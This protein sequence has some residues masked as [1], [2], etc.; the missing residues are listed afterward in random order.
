MKP[1]QP[2]GYPK[3]AIEF[4]QRNGP[5][6]SGPLAEAIGI[7]HK[8]LCSTLEYAVLRGALTKKRVYHL[9]TNCVEWNLGDGVSK[10]DQD[11]DPLVGAP[12]VF[13]PGSK[14]VN[15]ESAPKPAAIV[16][17]PGKPKKDAAAKPAPLTDFIEV[18]LTS[19]GRLLIDD[20]DTQLALSQAQTQK[21]LTY[22]RKA[23]MQLAT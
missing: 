5:T 21:V 20:G 22:L 18:A 17:R 9:G 4:I 8:Q 6:R 15:R 7:E 16:P 11:S 13:D 2:S 12:S 1:Y 10:Q 19:S 14:P 23:T 3:D